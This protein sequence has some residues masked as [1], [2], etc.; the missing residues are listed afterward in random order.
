ML[1]QFDGLG[2]RNATEKLVW[3]SVSKP[4]SH[5]QRHAYYCH[6]YEDE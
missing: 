6:T 1:G 5:I 2:L 3:S 4:G